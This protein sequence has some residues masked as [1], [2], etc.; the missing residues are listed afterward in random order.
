MV[1][2]EDGTFDVFVTAVLPCR[3]S[4]HVRWVRGAGRPDHPVRT[5]FADAPGFRG[6]WPGGRRAGSPT[7][8]LAYSTVAGTGLISWGLT[9]LGDSSLGEDLGCSDGW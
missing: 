2:A 7:G 9:A 3:R 5:E 4:R 1:R 6:P 8:E